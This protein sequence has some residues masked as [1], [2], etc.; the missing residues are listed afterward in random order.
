MLKQFHLTVYIL[1]FIIVPFMLHSQTAL[2]HFKW[3]DEVH[4]EHEFK[5]VSCLLVLP[6]CLVPAQGRGGVYRK[7]KNLEQSGRGSPLKKK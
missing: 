7:N 1:H 4:P 2:F 6:K 3:I 5:F